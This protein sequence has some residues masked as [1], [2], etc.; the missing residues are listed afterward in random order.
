MARR[1][2]LT[3]GEGKTCWEQTQQKRGGHFQ[4]VLHCDPT[5]ICAHVMLKKTHT[6]FTTIER[7]RKDERCVYTR[8]TC[9]RLEWVGR[10]GRL[11]PVSLLTSPYIGR[12]HHNWLTMANTIYQHRINKTVFQMAP[13][14]HP[15]QCSYDWHNECHW[16]YNVS[17]IYR[18]CG[19]PTPPCK[20]LYSL[21]SYNNCG[22]L[23]FCDSNFTA[24]SY[25]NTQNTRTMGYVFTET[26]KVCH[27]HDC[28]YLG[29]IVSLNSWK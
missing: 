14:I 11:T 27:L 18:I 9:S 12:S 10:L 26:K 17:I 20:I 15:E 3:F 21:L 29:Y 23:A 1:H 22:C 4:S 8:W 6:T 13:D 5:A 2:F 19:I 7:R 16:R 24:T 28:H 25:R